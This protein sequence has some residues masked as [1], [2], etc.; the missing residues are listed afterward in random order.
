ML[1]PF[2]SNSIRR[3]LHNTIAAADKQPDKIFYF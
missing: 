1:L 3:S 2:L